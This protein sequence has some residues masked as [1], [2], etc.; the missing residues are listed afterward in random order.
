MGTKTTAEEL[1]WR[2]FLAA[3]V[4]DYRDQRALSQR[5]LAHMA[6]IT[7]LQVGR[8]ESGVQTTSSWTL[9][10]LSRALSV[11]LEELADGFAWEPSASPPALPSSA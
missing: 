9:F 11:S 10:R 4:R 6:G 3:K 1:V 2:G 5:E 7:R 8:I